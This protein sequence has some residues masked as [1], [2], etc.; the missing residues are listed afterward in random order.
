MGEKTA[1]F[2]HKI[3]AKTDMKTKPLS[4]ELTTAVLNH[5]RLTPA[6]P[7]HAF[8]DA[9]LNAYV[10]TA[11]WETVFRIVKREKTAVTANCPRWPAEFWRDM[12]EHGGGGTCFESNYAFFSLL[13]ALG[14]DGYLTINNMGESQGCHTAIILLL[15]GQKWLVD[16]GIP[17]YTPIALNQDKTVEKKTAFMKY[18]VVPEGDNHYEISQRPHPKPYTFTLI[19]QPVTDAAY[20]AATTADYGV[21]GLFLDKIVINK[22]V[23][24]RMWRFNSTVTPTCFESFADGERIEELIEGDVE[25]A[26]SQKFGM[27]KTAVGL[28]LNAISL[29]PD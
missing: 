8:L 2:P 22:I 15:D 26:V 3:Y 25:T 10:R 4:T 18:T 16:V 5:F 29:F 1:V 27:D 7:D 21:D 28:A 20:R 17:L 6:V 14:F 24:E 12:M 11:P 9:L 19:D 13:L 23:D